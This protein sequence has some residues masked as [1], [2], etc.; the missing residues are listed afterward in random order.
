MPLLAVPYGENMKTQVSKFLKNPKKP[1]SR[2]ADDD[3][4]FY[5]PNVAVARPL[6][7]CNFVMSQHDQNRRP[8]PV[9]PWGNQI[10]PFIPNNIL[11]YKTAIPIWMD[12]SGTTFDGFCLV[13]GNEP[14]SVII[15]NKK[16]W[17]VAGLHLDYL[18]VLD[19][20]A[21]LPSAELTTIFYSL[22]N[23][24]WG[25]CPNKRDAYWLGLHHEPIQGF[26][27]KGSV[28][29]S[30]N[31]IIPMGIEDRDDIDLLPNNAEEIIKKLSII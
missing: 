28:I 12:D 10:D 30:Y 26:R 6:S 9:D 14:T 13:L 4:S 16:Y 25:L 15:N 17:L 19:T 21:S 31:Q 1:Y 29:S 11:P 23:P 22:A 8:I 24:L 3:Y 7:Q 27:N 5:R 2:W 18:S 20:G